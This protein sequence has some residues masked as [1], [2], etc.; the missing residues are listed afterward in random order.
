MKK[1]LLVIDAQEDFIGEQR[2]K[3]K[4]DYYDVEGLTRNINNKIKDYY[5]ENREVIYIAHVLPSSFFY[6]KFIG[7][8]IAGTSGAKINENIEIVCDN[9]FE[10]QTSNAFKNTNLVKFIKEKEISEVEIIGIDV[11]GSISAT[12][13]GALDLELK[14]SILN[15]CI[16]MMNEDKFIRAV[17]KLKGFG[18]AYL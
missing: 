9:Y 2:N 17:T 7:Y 16:G 4:F 15:D 6:R 11:A 8:G 3:K 14:V 18:V 5:S 13:K 10:K 12:A 1:A